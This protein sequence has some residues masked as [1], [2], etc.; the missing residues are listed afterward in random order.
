MIFESGNT[1]RK[2]LDQR[3]NKFIEKTLLRKESVYAWHKRLTA[4]LLEQI[5]LHY[6]TILD[7]INNPFY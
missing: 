7:S 2:Q 3:S 5:F 6:T 4:P 1:V